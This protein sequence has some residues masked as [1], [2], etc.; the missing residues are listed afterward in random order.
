MKVN[1]SRTNPFPSLSEPIAFSLLYHPTLCW[2]RQDYRVSASTASHVMRPS[3]LG[4]WCV[5]RTGV[6]GK[7]RKLSV[8]TQQSWNPFENRIVHQRAFNVLK[9]DISCD[10]IHAGVCHALDQP[11][12]ALQRKHQ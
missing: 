5:G 1:A 10:P 12:T 8:L 3:T 11:S 7:F 6:D 4:R 9:R 2:W